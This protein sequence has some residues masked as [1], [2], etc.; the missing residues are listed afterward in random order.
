MT[1][2]GT[3]LALRYGVWPGEWPSWVLAS[4]V[5][6]GLAVLAALQPRFP[7]DLEVALGLTALPVCVMADADTVVPA[8]GPYPPRAS[9][10]LTPTRGDGWGRERV[11][12]RARQSTSATMSAICGMAM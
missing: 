7:M 12:E 2:N 6:V 5:L 10:R 4:W 8:L 1:G 9:G 3:V 11:R